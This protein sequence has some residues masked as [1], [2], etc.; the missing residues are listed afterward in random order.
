MRYR[1]LGDSGLRTSVVGLGC[2]SIG[3]SLDAARTRALVDAAIE[4]G[5]TLFDTAESYGE[6]A[7]AGEELLGAALAGR[8]DKVVLATKFG[9]P[10]RRPDDGRGEARG[11]PGGRSSI[12]RAVEGSLRRLRTDYLDLY[13][14][15]VPDGVTPI[16][17]TLSALTELV[18]EGKVR[19]LG[20]SNVPGWRIAEAAHVA[21]AGGHSPFVSTQTHWSLL[22]RGA[23]RE[24]VPAA[25][26]YGVG[27]LPFFP[28][29][30]GLLTGKVRRGQEP[31]PGTRLARLPHLLTPERLERVEALAAWGGEHGRSV[32]EVAIGALA[33]L[34]GCGSVIAGA[35]GPE[36]IR[37]NAAAGDWEPTAGELA[38]I[39]ALAPL[40]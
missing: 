28:L 21:R 35:T 30:H 34:P 24:V 33:A 15:H 23:E 32:L 39:T 31:P 16:E 8:R 3:A 10:G 36:Q 22:E 20:S 2:N 29:A 11:A 17:E 7:G 4:A 12:R 1:T 5:V 18:R 25:V 9:A 14:Y 19:Y 27:V 13:Q 37:A 26:H 6:P 40:G 38:E